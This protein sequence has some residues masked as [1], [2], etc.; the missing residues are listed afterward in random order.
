ME[1]SQI[2][3]I[4]RGSSIYLSAFCLLSVLTS[5]SLFSQ[6]PDV[7]PKFITE[8]PV[9]RNGALNAYLTSHARQSSP[10]TSVEGITKIKKIYEAWGAWKVGGEVKSVD[11]DSE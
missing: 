5:C 10:W 1:S 2:K 4:L 6:S 8:N 7:A 3:Y 11:W 9:E